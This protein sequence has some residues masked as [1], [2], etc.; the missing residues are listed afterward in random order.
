MPHGRS[1]L[2]SRIAPILCSDYF[3]PRYRSV[4]LSDDLTHELHKARQSARKLGLT[5][6]QRHI[7]LCCD[8]EEAACAG[9]KE[10]KRSWDYLKER[11]K[12]LGLDGC[13]HPWATKTQ[14]MKVC[15]GG[16]IAVVYPEGT[17]YGRC[18]PEALRQIVDEHLVN[19]RI[20]EKYLLFVN[21][22]DGS[23]TKAPR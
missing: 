17:W 13:A 18:T 10:M 23:S 3:D 9:R 20:V 19:G 15:Q 21:P 7:F 4:T 11:V 6:I 22:L 1:R 8:T 5:S 2:F 12:E 16:P 14:C